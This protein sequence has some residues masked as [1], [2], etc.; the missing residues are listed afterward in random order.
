MLIVP[1]LRRGKFGV[2]DHQKRRIWLAS[3]AA[4]RPFSFGKLQYALKF[5]L[6]FCIIY[7]TFY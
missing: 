3:L 1:H 5:Y 6:I 2:C 7:D 4:L